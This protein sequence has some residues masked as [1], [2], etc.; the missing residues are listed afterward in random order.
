MDK[1]LAGNGANEQSTGVN[2]SDIANGFMWCS[3]SWNVYDF[4]TP[5]TA[6]VASNDLVKGLIQGTT[7]TTRIGN[8]IGVK[9]LKG[10]ITL[11]AAKIVGPSAGAT[12]GDQGGESI[13]TL[14]NATSIWEFLRTTFR[15][16]I[17]KDMQ[18]NSVD[19]HINWNDVFET[20]TGTVGETGGVHSE[21]KISNMGRFRVLADHLVKTDAI[22]PQETVRFM[23]NASQIGQIRY[24]GPS[25][26]SLTDKGIYVI[27]SAYTGNV[28]NVDAAGVT[29]M[30]KPTVTM[31]SRLCFTD[32]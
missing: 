18:V 26:V 21:L 16:V 12:N 13:A 8:K 4:A 1:A 7:A 28:V 6:K 29:G 5:G 30:V 32:D 31:H 14:P 15:V 11:T 2:T 20:G 27:W 23:V 9:F 22:C 24:N 25:D 17:V 3:E 10:A 19:T